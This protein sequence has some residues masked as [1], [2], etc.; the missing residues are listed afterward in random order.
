MLAMRKDK[1]CTTSSRA[2]IQ[3][4]APLWSHCAL[5]HLATPSWFTCSA[6]TK[7]QDGFVDLTALTSDVSGPGHNL[8]N[9]AVNI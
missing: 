4:Q 7:L 8:G 2:R 5:V 9:T 1:S 3:A 6:S